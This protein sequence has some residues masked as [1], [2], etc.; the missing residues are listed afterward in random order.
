MMTTTEYASYATRPFVARTHHG[1]GGATVRRQGTSVDG[2][3]GATVALV[4]R[5]TPTADG[6]RL[7][8]QVQF[9]LAP[10]PDNAAAVSY[11]AA[12]P[13]EHR[14]SY[15]GSA[16]PFYS[17]Q[18]AF[19]RTPNRG[20]AKVLGG[21]A[22]D[23]DGAIFSV[24]VQVPNAYYVGLGTVRVPPTL[25][26]SYTSHGRRYRGALKLADGTPFRTLTYP[27][28]RQDA[29]FYATPPDRPV[30]S[31]PDILRASAYPAQ[32]PLTSCPPS[33]WS[34]KPPV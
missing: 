20:N 31:Q 1:E 27:Q 15:S 8:L 34:G 14:A 25:F 3:G 19:E 28:Q 4:G 6:G 11:I 22:G 29:S 30:R 17:E 23:S 18:Q 2:V 9:R 12:S 16:L 24:R 10:V 26:V 33:F 5:P 13:A 7:R 21:Q 32:S